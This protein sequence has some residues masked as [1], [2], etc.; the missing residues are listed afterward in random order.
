MRKMNDND[1]VALAQTAKRRL[2]N[3]FDVNIMYLM[4]IIIGNVS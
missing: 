4:Y 2:R 1:R 3:L